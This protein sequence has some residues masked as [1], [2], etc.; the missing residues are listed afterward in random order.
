MP[1]RLSLQAALRLKLTDARI[2][3]VKCNEARP[4][5]GQCQA[6][7]HNCD[8]YSTQDGDLQVIQ[9][10]A[11][12]HYSKTCT[13]RGS[14]TQDSDRRSAT[15]HARPS[16]LGVE[17]YGNE[18]QHYFQLV[19]SKKLFAPFG[20][21][22]WSS[23]VAQLSVVEPAVDLACQA[24]AR[25]Y[26]CLS[27]SRNEDSE[28]RAGLRLYGLAIQ[29]LGGMISYGDPRSLLGGAVVSLLCVCFEILAERYINALSHLDGGLQLVRL[30][31][32]DQGDSMQKE[33][34]SAFVR[35]E[36]QA[37]MYLTARIPVIALDTRNGP[38]LQA[39]NIDRA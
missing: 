27:D 30:A 18:A 5:C 25:L 20:E 13:P 8:S 31:A 26:R 39:S 7:G 16:S 15:L 4:V 33:I 36:I 23:G 28:W 19:V 38:I 37:S 2:R 35:L 9:W 29:R 22:L 3:H 21:E 10:H 32:Q 34:F 14:F 11:K 12:S 24:V 6:T 17:P 1:V